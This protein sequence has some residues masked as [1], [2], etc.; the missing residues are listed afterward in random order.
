MTEY[1]KL[2]EDTKKEK[3]NFVNNRNSKNAANESIQKV[4]H[5]NVDILSSNFTKDNCS[6]DN[7]IDYLS[8]LQ[9]KYKLLIENNEKQVI[10][11]KE[12]KEKLD[13]F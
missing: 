6:H 5:K 11:M 2:L 1:T 13:Q 8:E 12:I 10:K 9:K 7:A 4:L 3:E